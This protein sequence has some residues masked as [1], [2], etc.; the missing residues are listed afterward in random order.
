MVE[1]E[2]MIE[3][4]ADIFAGKPSPETDAIAIMF[5]GIRTNFPAAFPPDQKQFSPQVRGARANVRA[6]AF[7][8]GCIALDKDVLLQCHRSFLA[9]PAVQLTA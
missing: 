8:Q 4:I 3:M 7:A 6:F 1:L 9:D 5:D 2:V